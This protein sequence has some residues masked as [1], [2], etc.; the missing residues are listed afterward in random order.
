MAAAR[1]QWRQHGGSYGSLSA[2]ANAVAEALRCQFGAVV[3]AAAA[4]A[5]LQRQR[6]GGGD[7]G[8]ATAQP[9]FDT[10]D[11]QNITHV[12]AVRETSSYHTWQYFEHHLMYYF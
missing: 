4:A 5:W 9:V 7:G 12:A 2:A 6:G 10:I 11:V 3:V 1:R 8:K